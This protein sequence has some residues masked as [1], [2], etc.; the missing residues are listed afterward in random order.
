VCGEAF[1]DKG[2]SSVAIQVILNKRIDRHY[3]RSLLQLN[4]IQ[5]Y[6]SG[7]YN[8]MPATRPKAVMAAAAPPE[9]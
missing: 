4:L 8:T 5:S 6:V 9:R 2:S 7:P 1:Q 3:N